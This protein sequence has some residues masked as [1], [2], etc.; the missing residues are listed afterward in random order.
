LGRK[1]TNKQL[2]FNANYI[3]L[4][5]SVAI[6]HPLATPPLPTIHITDSLVPTLFH[7]NEASQ[8]LL[9]IAHNNSAAQH[10]TFYTDGSVVEIG[11][12]QC[13][14]GIGWAQIH[15]DQITHQFAAQAYSWPSSYKAELLAILSAISTVPR[16]SIVD[17]FTDSQ[18]VISKYN[19]LLTT[20][21][22]SSKYFKFNSWPAWHTLLNAIQAFNIQLSF[23]KVQ[24]HT[25]DSYNNLADR[26]ARNHTLQHKLLFNHA[27]LH[28]P[29]LFLQWEG[30]SV[31]SPTRRFIRNICKA[32][33]IAMWSSQKVAQN[34]HTSLTI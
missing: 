15:N 18:S 20:S 3:D 33:I 29:Y 23:H 8:N 34:G 25:D 17:I 5:Y 10:F 24:A 22:H 14:M 26:L 19:K 16:N 1:T 27:N 32:H 31:E 21:R 30:H 9:R 11:T 2:K 6:K 4:I 13:S 28:N 7:D 12:N